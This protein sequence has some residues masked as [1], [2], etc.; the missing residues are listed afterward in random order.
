VTTAFNGFVAAPETQFLS[1]TDTVT[2]TAHDGVAV[3][4]SR[5]VL[6]TSM[7]SRVGHDLMLASPEGQK[8]IIKAFFVLEHPPSLSDGAGTIIAPDFAAKFAGP[9][10]VGMYAQA[11][12]GAAPA[13]PVIGQIRSV[14]GEAT[15][16]RADGTVVTLKVG[17][18]LYAD[19]IIETGAGTAVGVVLA[20]GTT[21]AIDAKA[22]LVLDELVYDPSTKSGK[23]TL[24]LVEGAASFVSG[25]IAKSGQDNMVFKTPVA[26]IGIRGTKVLVSLDPATGDISIINRPYKDATGADAVGTIALFKP[27]GTLIGTI[28]AGNGAWQWNPSTTD[29]PQQVQLSEAQVQTIAAR[30]ETIVNSM[31]PPNQRSGPTSTDGGQQNGPGTEGQG[32]DGQQEG[33]PEGGPGGGP[34]GPGGGEG[35]PTEG[36]P[37]PNNTDAPPPPTDGPQG[38]QGGPQ[39]TAGPTGPNVAGPNVGPGLGP[40]GTFTSTG[41]TTAGANN[42][43][44]GSTPGGPT[45]FN[46]TGPGASGSQSNGPSTTGSG[47]TQTTQ[48]QQQQTP[49]QTQTQI[50]PAQLFVSGGSAD[51]RTA[52]TITFTVTRSANTSQTT[53]VNYATADGSAVAGVDYRATSGTL[54][55]APGETTKTVT[56]DILPAGR[57][58]Q[59]ESFSLV[60]S[61]ASAGTVLTATSATGA[62]NQDAA[63]PTISIAN[64]QVVDAVNGTAQ[65]TVTRTGDLYAG[66][67]VGFRTVSGTAVAAA[68]FE[69]TTGT[70]T[71]AP[72]QA[73]ATITVPIFANSR[74]ETAEVFTVELIDAVDAVLGTQTAGIVTI[75]EDPPLPTLTISD[76]QVADTAAGVATLIV[77]RTGNLNVATTVQFRTVAGSA[78]ANSDF[79]TTTGPVT[80]AVGQ[81]QATITVPILANTTPLTMT[82]REGTETF[83]VELFDVDGGVLGTK[84]TGVVTITADAEVGLA[85]FSINSI[86]ATEGSTVLLTVT[87]SGDLTGQVS[88]SYAT[89]SG[90]A[91]AGLDFA[92]AAG[93]LV[94][95]PN[96]TSKT[97]SVSLSSDTVIE[98]AE[99]FSVVLQNAVGGTISNG[100]GIVTI[101]ADPVPAAPVEFSINS[102]N[103]SDATPGF[104]VLTITRSGNTQVAA[105]VTFSTSTGTAVGGSDYTAVSNTLNFAIGQTTATISIPILANATGESAET[106][107]VILSGATAE[108]ASA[109]ITSG[110]GTV[111]IA[112]DGGGNVAPTLAGNIFF[113]LIP[114]NVP[115]PLGLSVASSIGNLFMDANGGDTFAGLA[116]VGNTANATTQGSWQYSNDSGTTWHNIGTVA[117]NATALMLA[118]TAQI[119]F[120]P[121][122]GFMGQAP[123]LAYRAVDSTY[124]GGFSSGTTTEVRVTLGAITP[125]GSS[126]ISGTVN[127]A[128]IF[129]ATPADWDND[130]ADGIW[131]TATNWTNDT[132]PIAGYGATITNATV[133]LNNAAAN[134]VAGLFLNGTAA[135]TIAGGSTALTVQASG[136]VAPTASLTLDNGSLVLNGPMTSL[137]TVTIMNNGAILGSA[138][139]FIGGTTNLLG[140]TISSPLTVAGG[141]TLAVND[142][143]TSNIAS[144]N[145]QTGG[146]LAINSTNNDGV[147]ASLFLTGL[148]TNAGTVTLNNSANADGVTLDMTNATLNN[149]AG[150]LLVA[151]AGNGN[152]IYT[153][154]GTINNAGMIQ[155]DAGRRLNLHTGTVLANKMGGTFAGTGE[156]YIGHTATLR[157]DASSVI[158]NGFNIY[159][160]TVG[161][162]VGAITSTG[163]SVATLQGNLHLKNGN[164]SAEF[165]VGATGVVTA[166]NTNNLVT[167]S[168]PVSV[169]VGG[170]MTLTDS[171]ND[172]VATEVNF[173]GSVTNTGTIT[174]VNSAFADG[175]RLDLTG[176]HL[177]NNAGGILRGGTGNGSGTHTVVGNI[178]NATGGTIDVSSDIVFQGTLTN[179]G[180]MGFSPGKTFTVASGSL[181]VNKAGGNYQG[182]GNLFIADGG[183]FRM[184]DPA[185]VTVMQLGTIGG[186]GAVWSRTGSATA[187]VLVS[188]TLLSG[189]VSV[190]LTVITGGAINVNNSENL[191]TISGGLTLN[192]GSAMFLNSSDNNGA[193]TKLNLP[194]VVNNS[195]LVQFDN[196]SFADGVT[197]D[198]T[199]GMFDNLSAGTIQ[200]SLGSGTGAYKLIGQINN[201]GTISISSGRT[202]ELAPS[203]V[204]AH[205]A[206]SASIGNAGSLYIGNNAVFRFDANG[207]IGAGVN[208]TLGSIAGDVGLI[209]STNSSV[210]TLN[211]SMT[212]NRGSVATT[213]V[214]GSTG[215][216]DIT[217]GVDL[218]T[219]SG[220]VTVQSG[221]TITVTDNNNSGTQAELNVAAALQNSGTVALVSGAFADATKLDMTGG[222]FTN[223]AGGVLRGTSTGGTG[224]HVIVGSVTNNAGGTID[225]LQDV[226]FN[227]FAL[228]AGVVNIASGKTLTIA[229]GATFV[230]LSGGTYTGTGT[231]FIA[232]GG[233]FQLDAATTVNNI[234][235]GT[236]SGIAMWGGN[237]SVGTID[238]LGTFIRG[239]V[240]APLTVASTGA[241]N[242]TNVLADYVTIAAPLTINSG[243]V[244][245]LTDSNNDGVETEL[246]LPGVTNNSGTVRLVNS[247]FADGVRLD[248]TGGTFNNLV[249]GTLDAA[250]GNGSGIYRISGNINNAGAFTVSHDTELQGGTFTNSGSVSIATAQTF[251]VFGATTLVSAAGNSFSGS[252]TLLIGDGSTFR[253]DAHTSIGKITLGMASGAGGT[254]SATGGSVGTITGFANF[255]RGTVSAA[256]DVASGGSINVTNSNTVSMTGPLQILSGGTLTI[257]DN[258]NDGTAAQLNVTGPFSNA[259]QITLTNTAFADGATLNLGGGTLNNTGT[260]TFAPGTGGA[261]QFIGWISTSGSVD[262]NVGTNLNINGG[263]IDVLNG[264]SFFI[265][266]SV[267]AN[268]QGTTGVLKIQTGGSLLVNG[269]LNMNGLDL[270]DAGSISNF[271][272]INFGGGAYIVGKAFDASGFTATS[273][274][275]LAVGANGS[276]TGTGTLTIDDGGT[277][278]FDANGTM[279]STLLVNFGTTAGSGAVWS[280]MMGAVATVDSTVNLNKGTISAALLVSAGQLKV[281][282]SDGL[283]TIS[284]NVLNQSQAAGNGGIRIEDTT[285]GGNVGLSITGSVNNTGLVL[286]T[287][288][289][290]GNNGVRLEAIGGAFNNES[291]GT[292]QIAAGNG[293]GS[294]SVAGAINNNNGTILVDQ[295]TSFTVGVLQNK[296]TVSIATSK[297]FTVGAGTTFV[298]G[299]AVMNVNGTVNGSGTLHNAG[300]IVAHTGTISAAVVNDAGS[301]FVADGLGNA[302]AT[303]VSGAI[304]VNASATLQVRDGA[305]LTVANGF[306]NNG[307]TEIVNTISGQNA[308]LTISSGV[309]TNNANLWFMGGAGG[310]SRILNG[311]VTNTSGANILSNG[312]FGVVNGTLT[313]NSGGT[314]TVRNNSNFNV[315]DITN[316]GTINLTNITTGNFATLT[317]SGLFTNSTGGT[318]NFALGGSGGARTLTSSVAN[319][320]NFNFATNSTVNIGSGTFDNLSGGQ[321]TVNASV[322]VNIQD[323]DNN[324][325]VFTNASG[326]TMTINGTLNMNGTDL[327]NNGVLQGTGTVS[328]GSNGGNAGTF[329]QNGT[330]GLNPGASP[331]RLIIDGNAVFGASSRTLIEL[332]GRAANQNDFLGITNRFAA[333]GTLM[334]VPWLAFSAAAGDHF[335]V[336][337]WGERTRMFD[338]A[339]GLDAFAGVGLDP[340]FSDKGLSFNARAITAEGTDADDMMA[341]TSVDDVLVGRDGDDTLVGGGGDDLLLGGA[342]QNTFVGGAG[343][344]RLIGGT[345][346]DTADYS[347]ETHGI[348]ADLNLG[349]VIDG[350]GASDTLI[351]IERLLGSSFADTLVGN[352]KDNIIV[353]GAGSDTLT[354]GAG[355]DTFVFNAVADA[356]DTITDFTAGEDTIDLLASA[357]GLGASAQDGQNFSIIAGP[358]D[359]T[360][361]GANAAFAS[362]GPALV[363]STQ[364][365]ALYYDAN[366]AGEG[367]TLLAT[368]QSGG[369]LTASDI[370][371]SHTSVIG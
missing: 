108:G 59:L 91:L 51:D 235:L 205:K 36:G 63:L 165:V 52:S 129:S 93:E 305:T 163:G 263:F 203:A 316:A 314:I 100:S 26:T 277:L 365:H 67:T 78:T 338:E 332:G 76:V 50:Q 193:A 169:L 216:V 32:Q 142:S 114:N 347:G 47:T 370:Q 121:V 213:L 356:G 313:N 111:T 155:I 210:V 28:S 16:T 319:S 119:R 323:D 367:Y 90:S 293:L 146:N 294:R 233:S 303:F 104:A 19:D 25:Q 80:F 33:A 184:D 20:D 286:L 187:T 178:T 285:A 171:N 126:P 270:Y 353:G 254:W 283:V 324:A 204:L 333:G 281:T 95:G 282:D 242:I 229:S 120:L 14:T 56:V 226:Q 335:D 145:I 266:P 207:T 330:G 1:Q 366:G 272:N 110:V 180:T 214:V 312:T 138:P 66:S 217:N 318:I 202:F 6:L 297:T 46:S 75:T 326:A 224:T 275:K 219:L 361:A 48:P 99:T 113:G 3:L 164:V 133:T 261:R 118:A 27:D 130:A 197:L 69:A 82:N 304:S 185:N 42:G 200:F 371:L 81:A 17:D 123:A 18:P 265:A 179:H 15:V 196:S 247:G 234:Q 157:F 30:V 264:G 364:D 354:G 284:G 189:T 24:T 231:L 117:D 134:T 308:T 132:L 151:A 131:T 190:P 307:L 267:T 251:I 328:M 172:G 136:F 87:R 339:E 23:S 334:V 96:E 355:R 181:L 236:L 109:V 84:A 321:F 222:S 239:T 98:T 232:G 299:D 292:L 188:A 255:V 85:Q 122:A 320:G 143:N 62:I 73:T 201:Y 225:V 360:T 12:G 253:M 102:V 65:V 280:N 227:T 223:N 149:M 245:E 352:D 150:G 182:P 322:I 161:S 302:R 156:L 74:T 290:P 127:T 9:I 58:E 273:A 60:L 160:G 336:M 44:P 362:G 174:M 237:G 243:G 13:G 154:K 34:G 346:S 306:A 5:D 173:T 144:A 54:T 337:G 170:T 256:I 309:L 341:G 325:R 39:Q 244:V 57:N 89:A 103:V 37:G 342:G 340:I 21:L 128:T 310:G 148:I 7:Y 29:Q 291:G 49:Q 43:V 199:G 192:T 92:Q 70:V 300:L 45:S 141:G 176:G 348:S 194:S 296:G 274:R 315:T 262:V 250:A 71:F 241:I 218:V 289:G 258:N 230:N 331:G 257:S 135:L 363:F 168:G 260:L 83:N 249:G 77:T 195:G 183:T 167:F 186:A 153:V 252:G 345:D 137:G 159:L 88:V 107:A 351:S 350:T 311:D 140:G 209:A 22:E 317:V 68:D 106:F 158:A 112:A 271:A 268:L 278:R 53:T 105:N 79:T 215:T 101:S 287:S 359:G 10:A 206:V 279:G 295:D 139:L 64:V 298:N 61:G 124:A 259:G 116:I 246:N 115:N 162:E 152:G 288:S 240:T 221:G 41:I 94:F 343:A 4:P 72:F 177:Y 208:V 276:L 11:G 198:T 40:S 97:I 329:T 344:D 220:P 301:L 166:T 212:L 269:T 228:N 369:V 38:P 86:T 357:F 358:Y 238:G 147:Q 248:L 125:G 31:L 349:V 211:G 368:L 55:F 2:L 191:V 35:G 175:T 327:V 8:F